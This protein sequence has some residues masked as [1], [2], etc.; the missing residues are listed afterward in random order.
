MPRAKSP[1]PELRQKR[2]TT[3]M[4]GQAKLPHERDESNDTAPPPHPEIERAY[5]D[6]QAGQVD[7]DARNTAVPKVAQR[8][9]R[10]P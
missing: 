4:A 1:S 8:L 7:T 10:K 6:L 9:R 3:Q 2:R 5:A